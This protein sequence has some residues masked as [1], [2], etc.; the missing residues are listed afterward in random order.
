MKRLNKIEKLLL[1]CEEDSKRLEKIIKEIKKIEKKRKRLEDYYNKSY[2]K[3]MENKKYAKK[4]YKILDQ[5]SI[6]NVLND[7]YMN[8]IKLLKFLVK[9]I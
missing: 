8:K 5:D 4:S 9:T 2:L 1:T 7:D 3:D 6:W